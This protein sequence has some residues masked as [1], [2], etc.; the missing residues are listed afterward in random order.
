MQEIPYR[1]ALQSLVT[2]IN[3]LPRKLF[4]K[5]IVTARQAGQ[6]AEVIIE[7]LGEWYSGVYDY[8]RQF[9]EP[10]MAVA[11]KSKSH[12]KEPARRPGLVAQPFQAKI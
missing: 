7:M 1:E 10:I 5:G 2:M 9:M 12:F 3:S 6:I 8:I 4:D 11:A